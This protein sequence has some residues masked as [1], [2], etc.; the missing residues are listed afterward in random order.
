MNAEEVSLLFEPDI[1]FPDPNEIDGDI[2]AVGGDLSPGMLLSAYRQ[3]IFPWFSDEDPILWWSLDP[4]FVIFPG[5][6]HVSS[7]LRKRIRKA[8]FDIT[9][10][11]AFDLV[12]AGC[13]DTARSDQDG[14]WITD[15]MME[16]YLRLHQLGYAHSVEAWHE[17]ELSGGLYGVSIGGCYYGESMFTRR[18]DAS[19]VAF[20]ALAGVLVDEGFGLIDCQQHTRHLASFGAVDMPRAN[21]LEALGRELEKSTIKGNWNRRFPDFPRS[22]LWDNL[23][24]SGKS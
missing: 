1:R 18:T 13:R 9:V 2:I 6:L 17:G 5:R 3:G 22:E 8:T 10:D 19:K 24:R 16:A 7:S 21:F 4:R 14:T 15:D 12:I 23:M 11:K 20:T